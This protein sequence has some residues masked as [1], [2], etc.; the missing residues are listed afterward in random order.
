MVRVQGARH[1]MSGDSVR[2]ALASKI[3]VIVLLAFGLALPPFLTFLITSYPF[4][5][6]HNDTLF[7]LTMLVGLAAAVEQMSVAPGHV[8]ENCRKE[9][10]TAQRAENESKGARNLME[11]PG[12]SA[13]DM[14]R[15]VDIINDIADRTNLL[16]LNAAIEAASAGDAGKGF[17]VVAAEVKE[18]ARQTARATG[19]I[20]DKVTEL[21][22]STGT[23][24]NGM[25]VIDTVIGELHGISQAISAAVQQQSTTTNEI[26]GNVASSSAATTQIANAIQETATGLNTISS[27]INNVNRATQDTSHRLAAINGN[28]GALAELSS[29]LRQA[30]GAF[31]V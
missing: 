7:G 16:A 1:E 27:N 21:Q 23:A 17:A 9:L 31:K 6:E 4:A 30:V 8:A 26:V 11:S 29:K 2:K 18:L 5:S 13:A 15:V 14:G 20:R 12:V 25:S 22:A 24:I 28:I 19:E 10:E 3:A